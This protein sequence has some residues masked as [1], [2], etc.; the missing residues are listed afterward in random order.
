MSSFP[1]MPVMGSAARSFSRAAIGLRNPHL[2]EILETKP[3]LPWLEIHSE[4]YLLPPL[5]PRSKAIEKIRT[6]YDLSCHGV[7]LSLG[8]AGG[9]DRTHLHGLKDL[10]DR[11]QPCLVSEHLAWSVVDG[12]YFND[13]LPLPYSAEALQIV[14]DN[15]DLAQETLGRRLLIENPSRYLVMPEGDYTEPAFLRELVRRTGCGLLFDVNNLF[16]SAHNLQID[17]GAYLW[18]LPIEAIGEIHVA[19][20]SRRDLK[21]ESDQPDTVLIDDHGSVV[22]VAVW[23]LL[24]GLLALTGPRPVLVEWDNNIPPLPLLLDEARKAQLLIDASR[25]VREASHVA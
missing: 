7:G 15:I 12:R 6:T 21:G 19:G 17:V 4:N 11:L 24:D 18:D 2:A 20:H 3:D 22:P 5:A 8:S 23:S 25:A 16:V 14:C 13:L 9:L 1:D 10:Y